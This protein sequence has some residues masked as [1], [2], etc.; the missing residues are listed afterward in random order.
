MEPVPVFF[1]GFKDVLAV[2]VNQ[3]RP[4]LP[5]RVNNEVD[6]TNLKVKQLRSK[7]KLLNISVI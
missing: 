6:E 2:G 3:F 5:E 1:Q 4:G 7:V